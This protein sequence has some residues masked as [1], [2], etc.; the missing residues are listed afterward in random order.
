LHK[1]NPKIE[2]ETIFKYVNGRL[3]LDN[4]FST[5]IIRFSMFFSSKAIQEKH[6]QKNFRKKRWRGS[7]CNIFNGCSSNRKWK[8]EKSG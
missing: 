3:K 5:L 6:Q 1:K 7:I 4:R 2:L 8:S